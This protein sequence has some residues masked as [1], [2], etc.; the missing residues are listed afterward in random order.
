[1]KCNKC[2]A[3]I[4][5]DSVFCPECGTRVDLTNSELSTFNLK[6][7]STWCWLAALLLVLKLVSSFIIGSCSIGDWIYFNYLPVG[8]DAVLIIASFCA[9]V[10]VPIILFCFFHK[11]DVI[12]KS[13]INGIKVFNVVG[14]LALLEASIY[15][16][17]SF[18][19]D[20]TVAWF[21]LTIIDV[22]VIFVYFIFMIWA[23]NQIKK[24]DQ[25]NKF[26]NAFNLKI[27]NILVVHA[28]S[29]LFCL[30]YSI[31]SFIY[32]IV[33]PGPWFSPSNLLPIS[34]ISLELWSDEIPIYLSL[35]PSVFFELV[36]MILLGLSLKKNGNES[37]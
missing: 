8:I 14:C 31:F 21:A 13:L 11:L 10:I 32:W 12:N 28:I 34:Y 26:H 2:G 9:T 17:I 35:V 4:P 23:I 20:D 30:A 3:E 7:I 25:L 15:V 19:P 33:Y 29:L 1:M 36:F 24:K 27:S 18:L 5:E 6:G 37:V 22:V 16:A